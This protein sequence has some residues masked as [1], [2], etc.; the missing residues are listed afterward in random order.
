MQE[1]SQEAPCF[2][3]QMAMGRARDHEQA[4]VLR[5]RR[6]RMTIAAVKHPPHWGTATDA[7]ESE[8]GEEEEE[9]AVYL[10][11]GKKRVRTASFSFFS[12]RA[13]FN[14][15]ALSPPASSMRAA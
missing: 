8:E 10:I 13:S 11:S 1:L 4:A 2:S 14:K 15:S 7:L 6:A 12:V 5:G 3:A 9:V